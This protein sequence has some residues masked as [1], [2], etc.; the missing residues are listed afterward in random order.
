MVRQDALEG[1]VD[2][3]KQEAR[4]H[5]YM[6]PIIDPIGVRGKAGGRNRD[7]D[8]A[9]RDKGGPLRS[10]DGNGLGGICNHG[11][12]DW[13]ALIDGVLCHFAHQLRLAIHGEFTRGEIRLREDQSSEHAF[14]NR[15]ALRHI[16][17]RGVDVYKRRC[18]GLGTLGR[19]QSTYH[20][21]GYPQ[22]NDHDQNQENQDS[23][24]AH[25][26]LLSW[27]G[28]SNLIIGLYKKNGKTMV[29]KK[30][31]TL[32]NLRQ[33]PIHELVNLRI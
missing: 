33:S 30:D 11:N 29:V 9:W 22:C 3:D 12:G 16:L 28:C 32:S 20:K 7:C 27:D 31:V 19:E 1:R 24:A 21:Y 14:R 8:H 2:I 15:S 10:S 26:L 25:K 18:L 23:P 4:V 6:R 13:R 17:P 5:V